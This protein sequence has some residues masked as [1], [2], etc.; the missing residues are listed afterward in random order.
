MVHDRVQNDD[1]TLSPKQNIYGVC[2][3]QDLLVNVDDFT[4]LVK[5]ARLDVL[6]SLLV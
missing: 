5:I 3:T 4:L 1:V 2:K 6:Y